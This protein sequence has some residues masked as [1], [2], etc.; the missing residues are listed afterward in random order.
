MDCAGGYDSL[1]ELETQALG[2]LAMTHL[3]DGSPGRRRAFVELGGTRR[4]CRAALMFGLGLTGISQAANPTQYSLTD[5]GTLGGLTSVGYGINARGQVTGTASIGGNVH[6]HAFLY[7][8]CSMQDLGTLGGSNS[9]GEG[10]NASGQVTG[11]S[12]ITG[13]ATYHAFLYANGVMK[14]IDPFGSSSS[15]SGSSINASGQITGD[16]QSLAFLYS[17]GSM[18]I[19][20]S[21]LGYYSYGSGINASGVIVGGGELFFVPGANAFIYVNG[22]AFVFSFGGSASGAA[23][24]N[25]GSITGTSEFIPNGNTHAFLLTESLGVDLGTLGG[26]NS[27]GEGI[28]AVNQVTGSSDIPG[29]TSTHAFLYSNGKMLDL[30]TL[31][32]TSPLAKYVTLTDAPGI[33]DKGWIVVNGVDSRTG[34]EH[35][36]VLKPVTSAGECDD[37]D[38]HGDGHSGHHCED[39]ARC[40]DGHS[41]HHCEDQGPCGEDHS[42]HH[43]D[44][45][46]HCGEGES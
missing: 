25:S 4:F 34:N 27:Y 6:S 3:R 35:A 7:S 23:I 46:A 42:A 12:D 14:D 10:I 21:T 29:D 13:N 38:E 2:G 30:N 33:N 37:R 1:Q 45:D 22:V 41:G 40:D 36:Y 5:L 44:T 17:N 9:T 18:Q 8:G 16:E 43:C 15:S 28:N 20:A 11:N 19:L 24:N 39:H 32:T 31:D 26:S